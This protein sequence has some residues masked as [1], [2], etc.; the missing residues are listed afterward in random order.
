MKKYKH[1]FKK[2]DQTFRVKTDIKNQVELLSE[3]M[4]KKKSQEELK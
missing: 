3:A 1:W 2:S 4:H